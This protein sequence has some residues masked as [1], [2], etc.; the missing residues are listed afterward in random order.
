[1]SQIRQSYISRLLVAAIAGALLALSASAASNREEAIAERVKP[2]GQV[3]IQGDACA[4]ASVAAASAGGSKSP[5]EIYQASCAACHASG[6]GGAPI[7]GDAGAWQAR[8][9]QGMDTLVENAIKGVNAMPP[10]G[11][12]F[13]CSNDDIKATVE[14]MVKDL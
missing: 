11:T 10:M 2:A 5:E 1:M 6:V 12:C 7:T 4:T 3:C 13:S 8:M 14:Y 9:A